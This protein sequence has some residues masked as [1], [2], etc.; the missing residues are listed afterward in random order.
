M[1]VG[2]YVSRGDAHVPVR[3]WNKH[4]SLVFGMQISRLFSHSLKAQTLPS[5]PARVLPSPTQ[6]KRTTWRTPQERAGRALSSR[7]IK[8]NHL[9]MVV[10]LE[11]WEKHTTADVKISLCHYCE[12]C[13]IS[14]AACFFFPLFVFVEF[15]FAVLTANQG[16]SVAFLRC[17]TDT[18]DNLW[19]EAGSCA[20]PARLLIFY[21]VCSDGGS[22]SRC[23][24][25]L[26]FWSKPPEDKSKRLKDLPKPGGNQFPDVFTSP[27]W[28]QYFCSNSIAHFQNAFSHLIVNSRQNITNIWWHDL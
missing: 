22:E 15:C 3:K 26:D 13:W 8:R 19:S 20:A 10:S 4:T 23:T 21:H 28:I 24:D 18:T 11:I 16:Q 6:I 5:P 14:R 17:F 2:A 25:H 27:L 1:A 12:Q 7:Y 9:N